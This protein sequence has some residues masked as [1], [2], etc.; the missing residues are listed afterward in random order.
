MKK[1][2]WKRRIGN[3]QFISDCSYNGDLIKGIKISIDSGAHSCYVHGGIADKLVMENKIEE[4]AAALELIKQNGVPA[5]IGAHSLETVKA[6]VDYG[7]KPDYWMKTLHHTDYWSAK[8]KQQNDNIW[9]TNPEE[10]IEYMKKLE[11][12]WIAYK[13]LAAG[14][15]HPKAGFQYAFENGADFICVGI[16]DFQIVDD[17][18]IALNALANTPERERPWIT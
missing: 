2:I 4:I 15:I 11:Q 8:H 1:N 17:V 14:A 18:N 3:I 12:P 10:T 6:C 13:I 9:C 16:Y 5:G 7:L